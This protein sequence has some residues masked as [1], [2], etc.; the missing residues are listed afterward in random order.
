MVLAAGSCS[1]CTPC[2]TSQIR[3]VRGPQVGAQFART[4][5]QVDDLGRRLLGRRQRPPG[6]VLEGNQ[7]ALSIQVASQ[8][9]VPSRNRGDA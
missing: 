8:P 9:L 2:R 6:P 5:G 3:S 1:A 7:V 4:D